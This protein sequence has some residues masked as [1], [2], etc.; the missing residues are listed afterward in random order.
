M[1]L[2]IN[3]II[4]STQG[5]HNAMLGLGNL[6]TGD[7]NNLQAVY[8]EL[9][10]KPQRDRAGDLQISGRQMSRLPT[11]RSRPLQRERSR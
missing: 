6:S 3:E 8:Q 1:Q 11:S 7:L 10:D 9:E 5:A 2:K 4:S